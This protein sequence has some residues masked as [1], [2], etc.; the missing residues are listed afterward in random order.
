MGEQQGPELIAREKGNLGVEELGDEDGHRHHD[1]ENKR[2]DARSLQG[3]D[4]VSPS[5]ATQ[6]GPKASGK[7]DAATDCS[8]A[9]GL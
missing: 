3:H 9:C 6:P 4:R 8:T 5:Q 7:I 2:Q 1:G